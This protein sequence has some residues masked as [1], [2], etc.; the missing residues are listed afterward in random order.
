M[1][2][3]YSFLFILLFTVGQ[4][5]VMAHRL[6][7]DPIQ[8]QADKL[9]WFKEAKFGMFIHWGLYSVLG[10]TY[11][12]RTMPDTTLPNGKSWYAEW[13]QQRLEV[14]DDIYQA[15]KEQFNPVDFD[16]DRWIKEAKNAGM[17]YFVITAKHHDG[18]A[19]WDSKVSTYDIAATP[20]KGRDILGE[21]VE[22]CKKYGLKYGFYYS[23]WQ[24]WEHPQGALPY[25]KPKRSSEEFEKYWREKSLPQVQELIEN[26]DPDL[27][28]FDT[29][30][31]EAADLITSQRR[32]ELIGL[33]RKLSDKCLING[34]IAMHDP[35]NDIDFLEMMD[36]TYPEGLLEK[37]WQT[38]ATMNHTWAWHD[39]DFHWKSSGQMLRYLVSNASK[40]GNYLLN[41]G[42]KADGTLPTPAVQRLRE[43][44]AW[45]FSN[46]E[47]VYNSLPSE[48]EPQEKVV[49]T[50]KEQEGQTYLYAHVLDELPG[51]L[52]VLP[53]PADQIADCRILDTGEEL[54]HVPSEK[55]GVAITLP[56]RGAYD[57]AVAVV[58]IRLE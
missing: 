3:S 32:D 27:L 11:Q 34:R 46:G 6:A 5:Q 7:V 50:Q 38:P 30:D 12:G 22:A 47:A 56:E 37:P 55:G 25:W 14:P 18:F 8:E 20:F 21:L 51:N 42:P 4:Q 40:G 58:K 41:I 13:I 48:L 39:N 26:Y 9:T 19:L 49:F 10:G 28:W 57:V 23:H 44:G 35:G 36:N 24:D 2:N 1:R 16:A 54:K 45:M 15:L 29:W 52:L 31:D 17:K 43:M 53:L 33:I